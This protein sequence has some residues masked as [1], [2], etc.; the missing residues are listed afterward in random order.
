MSTKRES[1]IEAL[2]IWRDDPAQFVRDNFNVEPDLWQL[3]ALR[4]F[5][6]NDPKLMR[7]C[8]SACAGP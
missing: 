4:A 6:S 3:R 7:I 8:L 1:V 2:R 5:A